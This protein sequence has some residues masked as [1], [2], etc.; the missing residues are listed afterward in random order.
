MARVISKVRAYSPSKKD[1]PTGNVKH[2][3]YIATRTNAVCNEHGSTIFGYYNYGELLPN[4]EKKYV[5]KHIKAMSK[6]K[7]N[8][9]RGIISLREED[10]I[11]LGYD[12][13]E[14]WELMLKENIGKIGRVLNIPASRVEYCAVFHLKKGNPHIH[15]MF[16]DNKQTINKCY[17]SEFQQN[18]IRDIITKAIYREDLLELYKERDDIK[19]DLKNRDLIEEMK[20]KSLENCESKI[21]YSKI[22]IKKRKELIKE[23]KKI[24]NKLP[25]TRKISLCFFR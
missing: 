7:T 23:F 17:I 18:R 20:C 22:D 25:K 3:Y 11:N 12:E 13:R 19:K 6:D 15:Y 14:T 1:T 2:L 4:I 5:A 10:A 21:P 9:Y 16:W 8:I 24:A